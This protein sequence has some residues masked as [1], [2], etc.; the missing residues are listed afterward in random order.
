MGVLPQGAQPDEPTPK[1]VQEEIRR[2][3]AEPFCANPLNPVI[4]DNHA[5]ITNRRKDRL[6]FPLPPSSD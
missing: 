5:R 6:C 4:I 2:R 1:W 3:A